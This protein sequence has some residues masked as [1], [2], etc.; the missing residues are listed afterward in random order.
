MYPGEVLARSIVASAACLSILTTLAPASA[1]DAEEPEGEQHAHEGLQDTASDEARAHF[2]TAVNAFDVGQY[3]R[4]ATEFRAAYDLTQHPDLLYNVYS[5]LERAEGRSAEAA[6]AL[7]Q[8]LEQAEVPEDRR[9]ALSARLANLRTQLAEQRAE[10][11]E[12]RLEEQR[13]RETTNEATGPAPAEPE[14][15]GI[16]PAGIAV[17]IAGGVLLA[18]FGVFAALSEVEDGNLA[19]ECGRDV[20]NM[21][22]SDDRVGTL[23][24]YNIVADVSWI[25]G[26]VAAVTGI[27]L[28]VALPTDSDDGASAAVA[29]WVVPGGAGVAAGGRF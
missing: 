1:Q 29:P 19:S 16:H 11:A 24:A 4:A 25:A 5:A 28:L 7:E 2:D 18:N 22:C 9:A 17:L 8:Y 12:R 21:V 15:G 10:E 3:E 23:Q 20:P 26:A 14:G 27:V 6:D 13:A